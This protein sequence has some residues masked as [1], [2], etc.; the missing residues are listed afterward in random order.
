MCEAHVKPIS[1]YSLKLRRENLENHKAV[2][3]TMMEITKDDVSQH[4]ITRFIFII[5]E[6]AK[7]P[8]IYPFIT[9]EMKQNKYREMNKTKLKKINSTKQNKT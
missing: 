8:T 2:V 7:V 1:F 5:N 3:R 9:I 4:C 6:I